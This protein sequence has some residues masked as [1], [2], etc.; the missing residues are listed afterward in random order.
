MLDDEAF[1]LFCQNVELT[2]PI[3]QLVGVEGSGDFAIGHTVNLQVELETTALNLHA[4]LV[5]QTMIDAAVG[6]EVRSPEMGRYAVK[7]DD[8]AAE[9]R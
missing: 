6:G 5:A 8:H 3:V 9:H 7:I 4:K 1:T 2:L